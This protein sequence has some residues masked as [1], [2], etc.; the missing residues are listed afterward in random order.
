[1]SIQQLYSRWSEFLTAAEPHGQAGG[2]E[3]C[4]PPTHSD[5]L[6]PMKDWGRSKEFKPKS[7]WFSFSFPGKKDQIFPSNVSSTPESLSP[8]G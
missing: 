7:L 2:A 6:W 4:A 1:M 3:V 5:K 8:F